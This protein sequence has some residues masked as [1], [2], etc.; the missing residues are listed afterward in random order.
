M[1]LRL[2]EILLFDAAAGGFTKNKNGLCECHTSRFFALHHILTKPN[3]FCTLESVRRAYQEASSAP[4]F[5]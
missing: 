3:F 1:L 5:I 4:F 2:S